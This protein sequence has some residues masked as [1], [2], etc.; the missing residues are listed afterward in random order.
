MIL[1]VDG[2]ALINPRRIIV[3]DEHLGQSKITV[4]NQ[5]ITICYNWILKPNVITGYKIGQS[6]TTFITDFCF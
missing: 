6:I 5:S 1:N 2:S 3:R 4:H